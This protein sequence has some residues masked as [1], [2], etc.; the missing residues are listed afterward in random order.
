M[1]Y[2][3]HV[4]RIWR[5]SPFDTNTTQKYEQIERFVGDILLKW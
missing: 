3:I 2:R 5:R 4:A 1:M